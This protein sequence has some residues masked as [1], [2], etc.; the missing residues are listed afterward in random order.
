MEKWMLRDG[1]QIP[2]MGFGC[3]NAFGEE[4]TRAVMKAVELGYR[5]IDSAAKYQ[6][7][8]AVGEG[9]AHCGISREEVF[10]LSKVWPSFYDN[11][12]ESFMKTMKD[13][14]LEYL[15]AFILHW[16]GTDE[17]RRL[18]AYEQLL[19]IQEKGVIRTVGVSNFQPDQLEVIKEQFGEYPAL[20]QLECHPSYQQREK[21]EYCRQRGIQVIAYSPL[22]RTADLQNDTVQRIA[23]KYG[24]TAGQAVLRWHLEKG[25][26]P[27]PKSSNPKRIQENLDILDFSLSEQE[28]AEIDA[29]ESGIRSGLDPFTVND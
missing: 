8:E 21:V 5:Y 28:I 24:K 19:K 27:I 9:I 15:D 25:Q 16:P 20:N 10:V 17:A 18:R 2:K 23:A 7:E 14:Q 4:I 3:Y 6:N 13:L 12:E 1:N 26:I 11:V 22:N 29:L